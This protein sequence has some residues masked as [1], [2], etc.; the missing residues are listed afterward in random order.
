MPNV[1]RPLLPT[2][3][4]AALALLACGPARSGRGASA[5]SSPSRRPCPTGIDV[6]GG[7]ACA[8]AT[9][10]EGA[11]LGSPVGEPGRSGAETLHHVEITRPFLVR[12]TE[13]TQQEWADLLGTTPAAYPRCGGDCPVER[14]NWYEA[15]AYANALSATQGLPE[16]YVLDGCDPD[17]RPGED[18]SCDE[19]TWPDGPACEGFRLPTEAEWE[20]AARAAA[21]T[22]F[23]GGDFGE[24]EGTGCGEVGALD[25]TGWYC[26][27]AG[28]LTRPVGDKEPN[29]WGLYDVHGNVWEWVWDR[30]GAYVD[31]AGDPTGPESGPTR[32]FRGGSWNNDAQRCR[33]AHREDGAPHQRSDNRGLR[34][35]RTVPAG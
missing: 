16:C 7:W 5:P 1:A 25:R 4:V 20:Y 12:R 15:L 24:G 6:P 28:D 26:G 19:V 8:P 13:V 30:K 17:R 11:E 21:A 32:V 31:G 2:V 14:V 35:V 27:N 34:L 9:E 18:M 29:A 3:L 22:P 10:A 33:A 23:V